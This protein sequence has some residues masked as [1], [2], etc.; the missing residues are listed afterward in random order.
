MRAR[1]LRLLALT[2]ACALSACSGGGSSAPAHPSVSPVAALPASASSAAT[3][4]FDVT[5][6]AQRVGVA[7]LGTVRLNVSMK[8]R[9]AAGLAAYAATVSTPNSGNYHQFLTPGQIADRFAASASDYAAAAMYFESRGIGVVRWN[10]R[11]FLTIAGSQAAIESALGTTFATFTKNGRT[12]YAPT[13]P[14]QKLG[15]LAISGISHVSNYAKLRTSHVSRYGL[16]L[17]SAI[18]YSAAQIARAFDFTGAYNAGFTG[19]GITVG[20]IG[21]GPISAN[22]LATY[23]STFKLGTVASVTQV[24]VTNAAVGAASSKMPA[25]SPPPPTTN[26]CTVP[27]TGPS[28][29]C[30]PEDGE[31][32]LDTQQV[33][34]LAPGSN[35]LFYLGYTS[36][37][38]STGSGD[39]GINLYDY[40]LMQ[41]LHDNVADILSIS[42][43]EGE[44]DGLGSGY[45][46][47]GKGELPTLFQTAV[48]QGIAVMVASGDWGAL[49]CL[50]SGGPG[51]GQPFENQKCVSYPGTDPN[52]V[53]VGGVTTPLDEAGRL[54][55]P[56][57]GWGLQ[58]GGGAYQS[59]SGG[60]VS[61]YFGQPAYQTGAVGVTGST[62][63]TPDVS[64]EADG[65]TGVSVVVNAAFGAPQ[66]AS[67]GGS[68]IA[69]PEFAAM[70]ALVLQAC[71]TSSTC[72]TGPSAHPYRLGLPNAKL[73]SVYASP[74][75]YPATFYD[76]NFG[77]N[78]QL[79]ACAAGPPGSNGPTPVDPSPAPCPNATPV[80]GFVAGSGYDLVTGIG[81][82]FG[83]NLI[84]AVAGI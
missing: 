75:L 79:P 44:Q 16:P 60:G 50:P 37:D 47:T 2:L 27:T 33:A 48:A 34:A 63:N 64:L 1:R 43:G 8:M 52:V 39:E 5:T 53:S 31:A 26:A 30:N 6:G 28:A 19:K 14:A 49:E 58:T 65:T 77:D 73:Y 72:A 81:V 62:R 61:L 82:P 71:A 24:N 40:E 20:I 41:A 76:I 57:T 80:A 4:T 3:Q 54:V 36:N 84:K 11:E 29:S 83:R 46:N 68:S 56:M 18:G 15:G 67:F 23:K 21:T 17:P 22:D 78:S 32:Q 42:L 35:V 9:D 10:Q 55:A 59:A 7:T 51:P 38:P 13:G 66:F 69:A 74:T 70:W 12:F 45:D 25:F